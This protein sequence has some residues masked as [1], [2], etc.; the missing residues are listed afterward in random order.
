MKATLWVA[1]GGACGAVLR[2][3]LQAWASGALPWG[4]FA[5]NVLGSFAVGGLI[6]AFA[7][8]PWFETI[9]R[10]FLVAGVLGAFTTFSAFSADA[11]ALWEQE[12]YR[13]CAAYVLGSVV[14]SLGAAFAGYRVMGALT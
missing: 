5:A 13:W 14:L 12:R 4:T 2:Y 7:D 8:A 11:V 6:G 9:G 3:G 10:A 1:A